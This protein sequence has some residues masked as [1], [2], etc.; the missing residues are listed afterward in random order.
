M[1][2]RITL[3]GMRFAGIHGVGR[4]ERDFPQ[5]IEVDLQVETDLTQRRRPTTSPTRSTTGR[6]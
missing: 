2:D 6:W 3:R 1:S 4:E 5:V